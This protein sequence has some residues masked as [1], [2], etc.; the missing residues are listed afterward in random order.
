[1]IFSFDMKRLYFIDVGVHRDGNLASW[2]VSV[3][4]SLCFYL[5]LPF[6]N[7]SQKAELPNS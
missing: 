2:L 7:S 6:S 1:V 5:N 3:R 4:A